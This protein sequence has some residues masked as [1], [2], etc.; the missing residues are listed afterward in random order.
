MLWE[1]VN[2][3]SERTA[4]VV[5]PSGGAVRERATVTTVRV[6]GV[7]AASTGVE[8]GLGEITQG[9]GAPASVVFESW[10]H[11]SAFDPLDGEPA[12]SL[13]P[14]LLV[15][16][17]ASVLVALVLGVVACC[18]P[19]RPR[20]GR[21]LVGLSL[22]LLVVGGGFGPPLLGVL[23]GLLASR[24]GAPPSRQPGPAARLGA[25]VWPWTLVAAAGSFLGLVPGMSL[26]YAAT[27]RD[28]SVV[29]ASLTLAAFT[30]TGLAMWTARAR[31]RTDPSAR[32]S[33]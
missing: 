28:I 4:A 14:D 5:E 13:V 18:C 29:V 7:L 19:R 12:M 8:H 25:S 17:V 24:I 20:S 9:R 30:A 21:L 1:D 31:D 3:R 23:T 27:D 33:R 10:P 6:L 16:G 2:T 32:S 26:L 11:V 15:S 22:L